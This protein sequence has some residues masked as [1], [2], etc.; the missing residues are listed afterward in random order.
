MADL[1]SLVGSLM[2][3]IL[4]ARRMADEQTAALAEYYKQNP[5][6][7][8][9]SV[10]RIRIPE[11]SIELPVIIE[12][13]IEGETGKMED[14]KKIADAITQHMKTTLAKSNLKVRP[15]FQDAFVRDLT[16]QLTSLEKIKAPVTK[17]SVVR[18]VQTTFADALSKT[19]TTIE[20]S[21]RETIA[22]ELR[23]FITT[24]ELTT[25]PRDPSLV[26]NI[27][28]ADVKEKA[29]A[30]T[31]VRLRVTL[32]EEGLEWATQSDSSGGVIRTLQPE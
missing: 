25:K 14:P 15:A 2:V 6:L 24:I 20:G 1:G 29:S 27:K 22:A 8:G 19:K 16:A 11:L 18:I 3:G 30:T 32:K 10:P 31:V 4:R 12:D 23:N 17:E 26:A 21:Q 9:I 28:T 7:E 5:V 13:V